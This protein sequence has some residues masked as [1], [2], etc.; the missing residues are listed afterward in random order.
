VEVRIGVTQ[1]PREIEVD[2]GD[3]AD[4]AVVAKSVE[5]ALS[6]DLGVL[7]LTDRKGRRVGV[8]AAKLAYVEIGSPSDE[9][10]VGFGSHV[11]G[12]R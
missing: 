10:R 8:P 11:A 9:R 1:S 12:A 2:L 6:G 5:D 3:D 7:W 4:A